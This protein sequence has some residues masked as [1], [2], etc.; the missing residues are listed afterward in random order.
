M[1]RGTGFHAVDADCTRPSRRVAGAEAGDRRSGGSHARGS[2]IR[3]GRRGLVAYL[4]GMVRRHRDRCQCPQDPR[5]SRDRLRLELLFGEP[6][7]LLDHRQ[8]HDQRARQEVGTARE[9]VDTVDAER[10][11][12]LEDPRL[13][14]GVE[15]TRRESAPGRHSAEGVTQPPR[16]PGEVVVR[17]HPTLASLDHEVT[18]AAGRALQERFGR[19]DEAP[20]E[21][22]RRALG[23]AGPQRTD[24]P[25]A[26]EDG[27]VR[28]VTTGPP[29]RQ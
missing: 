9:I 5:L 21:P 16:H 10:P 25:G 4:R 22:R 6:V 3:I 7:L 28:G 8:R 15:R 11:K 29:K 20:R 26:L 24:E 13:A 2:R 18:L 14:V 12:R 19:I 27:R 23:A 1:P 17:E